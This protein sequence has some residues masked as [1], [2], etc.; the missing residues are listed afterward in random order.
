AG[1]G[2]FVFQLAFCGTAA[3]IVSGAVAERLKF[4]GYLMITA[5]VSL[6][7]YPILGHWAW[8]GVYSGND[9]GW[10]QVQGFVDFAGSTV[11]HSVGGWVALAAL[12]V[13]GPRVGRFV[14]GEVQSINPGNL[15]M[16]ML[17]GIILWFGWIGFNGG[18]SL[19]MNSS[20]APIV[21]KTLLAAGAGLVVSL[22]VGWSLHRYPEATAPLNGSL[23]GLVAITAGCHAVSTP[24]ALLIGGVGGALV[25]P[26][27]ILLEKAK[28]DDAVGAI[29]VH[30][31]AGIW[32]T[33]AVALF[34][35]PAILGTGL[36]FWEQLGVQATGILSI[37]LSAFLITYL[38][39]SGINRIFPLRVTV[40]EEKEGLNISEHRAR[41]DLVDLFLV[42]D[43][44]K[45]TGDLSFDVPV[46]P[47][48]EVGQIAERYNEVL[49]RVRTIMEENEQSRRSIE[50]AFERIALE[51]NRAEKLLLNILPEPV[52]RELKSQ[53]KV[54]AQSA[55]E[56]TILFA[57]IVGFTSLA[58]SRQPHQIIEI[59]NRVFSVFDRL[60]DV[61]RLEKIK[62][63]GDAYMVVGGLPNYMQEH[64]TSVARFALDIMKEA[65]KFR[66]RD[67]QRLELRV[68]MHTGPVVAGVIGEKKFIYDI[69][70]DSVNVAS[71]LESHSL[72]GKIHLSEQTA[73][74]I[75]SD[76]ELEERGTVELKGKG[77]LLTYFLNGEREKMQSGVS[78]MPA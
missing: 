69:W 66:F 28:I 55:R 73:R 34:G 12:L 6:V 38:L 78:P 18:S 59:L 57:D 26:A 64:A 4:Q 17:G 53:K 7:I 48:T 68:G 29:P 14:N 76:F 49:G 54:I 19:Q 5:L 37:G 9:A 35:D 75:E 50:E 2:F 72:P 24:E 58:E 62:T 15:P 22:I 51:Q 3:T 25:R 43:H 74:L 47:F 13:I 60:T 33:L 71:R 63:I 41:T 39:L 23:A 21:M 70:G 46:E 20:V 32:G 56:V 1:P 8:H 42:M 61:Y 36:G 16:A 77:N 30:L 31:M 44:Q 65:R 11:V 27:E 40:E 52:A 45:R 67:G 10:L